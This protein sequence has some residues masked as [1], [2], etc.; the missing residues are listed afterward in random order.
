MARTVTIGGEDLTLSGKGKGNIAST[1][2]A[3]KTNVDVLNQILKQTYG[4]D[5]L[6][7]YFIDRYNAGVSTSRIILDLRYGTDPNGSA[8]RNTYL[9]AFPGMDEFLQEGGR[10]FGIDKPE[11]AYLSYKTTITDTMKGFLID[12]SIYATPEKIKTYIK[13]NANPT[14]IAQRIQAADAAVRTLPEEVKSV[15]RDYYNVSDKD[16]IGYYLDTTPEGEN[17]LRVK[18]AA[19]RIGQQALA[20]GYKESPG[21]QGISVSAAEEYAKR[22]VSAEQANAAFAQIIQQRGLTGGTGETVT[23]QDLE[24]A[25]IYGNAAALEKINRVAGSRA[26]KFQ[27]G[28]GFAESRGGIS[29]LTSASS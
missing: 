19:A 11:Q 24:Q 23:Q 13:N 7:Q 27:Q 28:G 14:I 10:F 6:G 16:L 26:A 9:A 2:A 21:V 1:G 20:Q 18:E 29:G 17:A 15:F 4:L 12:T 22:G 5:N 8:A 3:G 25:N